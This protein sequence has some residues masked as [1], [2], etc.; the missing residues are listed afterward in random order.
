V[1]HLDRF[2]YGFFMLSVLAVFV[3]LSATVTAFVADHKVP[4][5]IISFVIPVIYFMGW[6]LRWATGEE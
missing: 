6:A 5:L 1:K 4:C 3:A 2:F